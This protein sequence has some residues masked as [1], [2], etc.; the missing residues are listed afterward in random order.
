MSLEM[1]R[2]GAAAP[3]AISKVASGSEA[4]TI[5][6]FL[7]SERFL[8][9]TLAIP[10]VL[11]YLSAAALL[12]TW[13]E[14]Q[15]RTLHHA[16]GIFHRAVGAL[17][18]L[19]PPIA[20][21]W[22]RREWWMHLENMGEGWKWR[23]DDIRWLLLFPRNAMDPRVELPEQGKFNAAEKLNFMMVF[24]TY[25]LYI[26]TGLMVWLPGVAFL[27]W[28]A[29]VSAAVM[30]IPL[31]AGHI[32]MATVNPSTR[33]GLS[34]M[35]TGIVDR[36]WARHHYRRWY[37]EHFEKDGD[38]DAITAVVPLLERPALVRCQT[39]HEVHALGSWAQL[40]ERMFQ[41]EPL[42]CPKCEAPIGIAD[43]QADPE[44]AE[45]IL[46]HLEGGG[47][48]KPFEREADPAA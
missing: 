33:I 37:R 42:F 8:H 34:G 35:F 32:F 28:V 45:A 18:I 13:G 6:R 15:P 46:R 25:P 16:A 23:G 44:I 38:L 22:G 24:A 20:L 26:V 11:L 41:V 1:Q 10:F 36:E 19:G 27:P 7:A 21:L 12:L 43:A 39:C 29:H 5:Q 17:L 2:R 40:L 4:P 14:A 31:V 47:A 3:H 9:W 48:E 30:G